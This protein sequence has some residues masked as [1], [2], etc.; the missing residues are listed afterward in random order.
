[1]CFFVFLLAVHP[2]ERRKLMA[3]NKAIDAVLKGI[4]A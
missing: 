4:Q 3:A 1:L 2:A